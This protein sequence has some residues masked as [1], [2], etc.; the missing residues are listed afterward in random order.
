MLFNSVSRLRNLF[1][2]LGEITVSPDL[3]MLTN[4][5]VFLRSDM[6]DE[7]VTRDGLFD[8]QY[9]EAATGRTVTIR[10]VTFKTITVGRW[11]YTHLSM[12]LE[13]GETY[14]Y[15]KVGEGVP[16]L[17]GLPRRYVDV[18]FPEPPTIMY[19]ASGSVPMV[20]EPLTGS[21]LPAVGILPDPIIR[22]DT[23]LALRRAVV[24]LMPYMMRARTV[25][26]E[27]LLWAQENDEELSAV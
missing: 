19:G 12:R 24:R 20:T 11:A 1:V 5:R 9:I 14:L 7:H 26:A 27:Y 13:N 16:S 22:M 10:P 15:A 17:I 6:F 2:T 23:P 18:I 8:L 25:N 21:A 3:R 4:G